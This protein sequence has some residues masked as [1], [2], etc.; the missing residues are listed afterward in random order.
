[1]PNKYFQLAQEFYPYTKSDASQAILIGPSL[2]DHT[3]EPECQDCQ[4]YN[5]GLSFMDRELK[6][7]FNEFNI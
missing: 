2:K 5:W 7:E 3:C 6:G 1:M 4:W